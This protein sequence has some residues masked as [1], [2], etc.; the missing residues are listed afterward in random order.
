VEKVILVTIRN[1]GQSGPW[2]MSD[3]QSELRELSG[4][5]G[6]IILDEIP[7]PLRSPDASTLI[8]GGKVIQI[9]RA[10]KDQ[11]ADAVIFSRDLSGSQQRNLEDILQC[12]T[13]DRTQL[14]LDIFARRARSME[15]KLQVELAQLKYLLPRLSGR[16]IMLSRLGGGIGTRGPGE[17]KLEVDRRRI[18]Y[19]V[20]ALERDLRKISKRRAA[21][22]S[23]RQA[24]EIPLVAVVGYTNAGKSTLFNALTGSGVVTEDRLFSTLDPTIRRFILPNRQKILFT[25]T[26]GFLH[27]LPHGLIEAFQAT[28]EEVVNADLILHILDVADEK[29]L[30]EEHS[31]EEVLRILQADEKPRILVLN[32]MD[33]LLEADQ[34]RSDLMNRWPEGVCISAKQ[35][36]GLKSLVESI[37]KVFEG[38]L[39]TKEF[40]L[41][42]ASKWIHQIYE[43]GQVLKREDTEKGV[44]IKARLSRRAADSIS[45]KSDNS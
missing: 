30:L 31:V 15:G 33:K 17:Q 24:E 42:N 2:K 7:A 19:R 6:L 36:E 12:K 27:D 16:G 41:P 29:A 5:C 34:Q 39:V 10:V 21:Y 26:V 45:K 44:R 23:R 32:K 3:S 28:L 13:I 4:S 9:A 11:K 37:E 40:Y 8:G 43:E 14:I 25:D 20:G 18:R 22:R 38:R 35:K 1:V